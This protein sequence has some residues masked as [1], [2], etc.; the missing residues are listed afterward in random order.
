MIAVSAIVVTFALAV[1]YHP[2]PDGGAVLVGALSRPLAAIPL[3][4]YGLYL[5]I[6]W[7]DIA[8]HDAGTP[9]AGIAIGKEWGRLALGLLVILVAVD[10]LVVS[11][12]SL[13]GTYG[14]PVFLGG[15]TII[16]A[17]TSLPDTLVSIR[18]ARGGHSTTSLANVF[19][20]NTFDLLVAIPV[21]VMIVGTVPVNFTVA[22]PMLGVLTV[23]T[24][25]LFT[26]LRTDLSLTTVESY[27]LL[28]VYGL[29]VAWIVAETVGVTG[30]LVG[31]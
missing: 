18:S 29:F 28:A 3:L 7:Q 27:A 9:P 20:S 16:A 22:A 26:M 6:Q 1:I 25:L 2:V 23:A 30:L 19:G 4:L 12:E 31:V 5:F 8:D 21:G 15:V 17:A 24:I 10:G 11:V 14:I 13:G